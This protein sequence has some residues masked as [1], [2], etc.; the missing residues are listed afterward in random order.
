MSRRDRIRQ[1]ERRSIIRLPESVKGPVTLEILDAGGKVVRRYSSTDTPE[2]T[3]EELEKQLIPLYWIRMPRVLPGDA[4]MHRW[5]W[6]LR[7]T[8]PVATHY[9]YPISAVPHETPRAPQGP[10]G[11]A[12]KLSCAA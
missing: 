8:T 7:Y 3:L 10:A 11:A 2:P 1:T 12:G 6:D 4:G 9:E 5:V